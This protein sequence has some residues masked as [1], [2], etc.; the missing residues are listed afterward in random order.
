[1]KL[2]TFLNSS[3]LF[4]SFLCKSIAIFDLEGC[5]DKTLKSIKNIEKLGSPRKFKK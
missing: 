4:K 1:M 5:H 3:Q 2:R